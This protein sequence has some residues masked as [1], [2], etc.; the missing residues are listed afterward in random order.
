[1]AVADIL[2]AAVVL[3]LVVAANT[4]AVMETL[5]ALEDF[6]EAIQRIVA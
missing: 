4:K 2:V 3:E 5:L 1:M 6:A